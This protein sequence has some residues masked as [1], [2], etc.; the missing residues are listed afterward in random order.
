MKQK[1]QEEISSICQLGTMLYE[2][3]YLSEYK[4]FNSPK[5]ILKAIPTRESDVI[6]FFNGKW[7]EY[8][9]IAK[10]EE[11]FTN[12]NLDIPISYISGIQIQFP[13]GN[14]GEL[15]VLFKIGDDFFWFEAKTGEYQ[16]YVHKYKNLRKILGIKPENS[17]MVI[18][19][20]TNAG[21]EAVSSLFDMTVVNLETFENKF[22]K[23][24]KKVLQ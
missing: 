3:A 10:I 7:L 24:L 22:L 17:F 11:I 13:N 1:R 21:A 5:Y 16:N 2:I 14:Y 8:Y 12:V 23:S 18:T 19:D 20:I 6:N 15:D 9:V 4:Y